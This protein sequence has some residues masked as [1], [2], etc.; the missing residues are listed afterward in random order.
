MN[1]FVVVIFLLVLFFLGTRSPPLA[2]S[3]RLLY[4]ASPLAHSVVPDRAPR[5]LSDGESRPSA[6][7][8]TDSSSHLYPSSSF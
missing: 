5:E 8:R 4:E 7:R 1:S 6:D 2:S 3:P